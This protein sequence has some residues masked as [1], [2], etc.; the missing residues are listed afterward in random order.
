MTFANDVIAWASVG[1]FLMVAELVVPGGILVFLGSAAVII[2]AL[3]QF[4]VI[5]HWVH[6]FTA[7]FI[8]S[9]VLLLAFRNLGQSLV[10]G[11]SRID[12]TDEELDVYGKQVPVIATIGP[13]NKK[14]RIL[15]QGTEWSA[16]GD[17]SEIKAGEV[18]TIICRDNISY[19]VERCTDRQ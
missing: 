14:G 11:D 16:L 7:W 2:A 19:V 3:L 8:I 18:A 4:G 10:G 15:L 12:N 13:G 6:A 5:E 9:I 1:V 17:G